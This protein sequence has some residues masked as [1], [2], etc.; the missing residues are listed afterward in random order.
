MLNTKEHQQ[1]QSLRGVETTEQLTFGGGCETLIK[2]RVSSVM[3]EG[4]LQKNV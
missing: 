1:L 4:E 3:W 2:N